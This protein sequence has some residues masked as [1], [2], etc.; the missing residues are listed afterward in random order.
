[1]SLQILF[2]MLKG[3]PLSG[4]QDHP[5]RSGGGSAPKIEPLP[6]Y[7]FNPKTSEYV[8]GNRK[9]RHAIILYKD[10]NRTLTLKNGDNVE[11]ISNKSLVEMGRLGRE[12]INE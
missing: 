1:M 3:G 6:G 12:F 7:R 4:H 8:I 11:V 9:G 2:E 10:G 5:G